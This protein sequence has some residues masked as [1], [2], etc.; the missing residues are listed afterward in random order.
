MPKEGTMSLIETGT[1]VPPFELP[2]QDDEPVSLASLAG[3]WVVLFFY[4]RDDTP[5]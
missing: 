2:N 3:S 4:P 5:G 1:E